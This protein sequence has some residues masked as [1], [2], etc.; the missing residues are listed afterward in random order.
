[1]EG[2]A[3]S[4]HILARAGRVDRRVLV[5]DFPF[6]SKPMGEEVDEGPE[7]LGNPRRGADNNVNRFFELL[8]RS[9]AAPFGWLA[10]AAEKKKG[11]AFQAS[12][13]RFSGPT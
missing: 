5:R 12:F 1:V 2:I 10:K 8:F 3:E 11:I 6:P 9:D 4:G 13:W 7:S